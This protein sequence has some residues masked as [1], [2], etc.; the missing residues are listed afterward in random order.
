MSILWMD[1]SVRRGGTG[2]SSVSLDFPDHVC[3]QDN[4]PFGFTAR[5]FKRSPNLAP[6]FPDIVTTASA[7]TAL[8]PFDSPTVA[9]VCAT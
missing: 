9:A 6:I 8:N 2:V 4:L 1:Q 3:G 5:Q 7:T